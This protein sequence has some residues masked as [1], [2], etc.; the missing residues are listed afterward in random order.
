[1]VACVDV[2]VTEGLDGSFG[3]REHSSQITGLRTACGSSKRRW[4][5]SD[6]SLEAA[7]CWSRQPSDG[8]WIV[9]GGSYLDQLTL[10]VI[11]GG[12]R[13]G[14]MR[15]A[16]NTNALRSFLRGS[17]IKRLKTHATTRKASDQ[18]REET[19]SQTIMLA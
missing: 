14:L 1:M 10:P 13:A 17:L 2:L 8:L 5:G 11:S 9:S 19:G 4:R 16:T 18:H 3:G 6:G 15:Q 12:Q 7:L